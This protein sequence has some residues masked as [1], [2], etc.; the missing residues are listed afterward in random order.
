MPATNSVIASGSSPRS[1]STAKMRS[2]TRWARVLG[3]GMFAEVDLIEHERAQREHR[4][5]DFVA[6]ADVPVV[7][8]RLDEVVYEPVDALRAG[9]AEQVDLVTRQLIL[10]EDPV[11]DRIVDVV[12]DVRDAVDDAHDFPLE[13]LRL[14]VAGVRED[15]VPHLFRE[16]QTLGDLH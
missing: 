8:R 11:A 15:S 5:A 4:L 13:R 1:A 14:A 7:L 16:V 9:R 6:L 10:A 12:V 3:A 2:I